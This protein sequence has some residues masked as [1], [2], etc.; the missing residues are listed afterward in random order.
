MVFCY[1]KNCF[2]LQQGLITF[3]AQWIYLKRLSFMIF[4]TR[5][6][7]FE[8]KHTLLQLWKIILSVRAK[9]AYW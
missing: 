3:L 8:P 1:L 6:Q 4:H 2:D 7:F 5:K 9:I